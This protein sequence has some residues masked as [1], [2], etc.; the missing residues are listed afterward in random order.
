MVL[1]YGIEFFISKVTIF[2]IEGINAEPIRAAL[3]I[4]SKKNMLKTGYCL[5]SIYENT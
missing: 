5:V 1:L 3:M 4:G 2:E